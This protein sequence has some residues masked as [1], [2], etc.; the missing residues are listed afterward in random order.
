MSWALSNRATPLLGGLVA[1]SILLAAPAHAEAPEVAEQYEQGKQALKADKPAEALGHFKAALSQADRSL[2][3]TWQMLLAVALTYQKLDEPANASEM[4]RRFLEV[5]EAH[6]DLMTQKWRTRREL[7]R[8]DLTKLEQVLTKPHAVVMVKSTPP[9]AEVSVDG[10]RA[11]VDGDAVTPTRLW[12]SPG[13]H[14]IALALEGF[15]PTTRTM[16]LTAG[17]L[18]SVASELAPV[19][20]EAPPEPEAPTPVAPVVA[21]AEEEEGGSIG[22]WLVLGGA[23]AAAIVGGFLAGTA[24]GEFSTAEGIDAAGQPADPDLA[25][26]QE[27][28]YANARSNYQTYNAAS[29]A[30]FSLAGAAAVGGVVWLLLDSGDDETSAA[31]GV[32]PT[33]QGVHGFATWR[34]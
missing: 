24:Q 30:M 15:E 23:G 9:G 17:Q 26:Q 18:D 11:G 5:T 28:A 27:Q 10:A 13:E 33:A 19:V 1:F 14:T 16:A 2:G 8:K 20:V 4:F 31:F 12:L 21:P 6:D 32:L 3:S 22:P 29:I 7:V 34:F 25:A